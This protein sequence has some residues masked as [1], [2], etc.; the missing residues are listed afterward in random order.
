[1]SA[2]SVNPAD[3]GSYVLHKPHKYYTGF[4]GW[5][6]KQCGGSGQIWESTVPE[7]F[8]PP[9]AALVPLTI[10]DHKH[11]FKLTKESPL[12]P[13]RDSDIMW[14]CDWLDCRHLFVTKRDLWRRKG[15]VHYDVY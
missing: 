5:R 4:M 8:V 10:I 12:G 15:G 14:A 6:T 13:V 7:D 3:C 1:M 11:D 9:S 2:E